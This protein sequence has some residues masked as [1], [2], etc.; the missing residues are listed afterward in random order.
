MCTKLIFE[1]PP[2][3][4]PPYFNPC[5]SGTIFM[6]TCWCKHLRLNTVVE[7]FH[8][9]GLLQCLAF[10][11]LIVSLVMWA[12]SFLLHKIK[13][14]N[15]S[16]LQFCRN[17]FVSCRL[18]LRR[19]IYF[20]RS[21]GIQPTLPHSCYAWVQVLFTD[22]RDRVVIWVRHYK[23]IT[24]ECGLYSA[25][26]PFIHWGIGMSWNVKIQILVPNTLPYVKSMGW[27]FVWN[28]NAHAAQ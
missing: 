28:Q 4:G 1:C 16:V 17:Q 15:L 27:W 22:V 8:S 18:R 12:C 20:W 6:R 23:C 9:E 2:P 11:A 7:L 10:L 19:N 21:C 14:F 25:V 5:T 24:R 13:C 3:R 26:T